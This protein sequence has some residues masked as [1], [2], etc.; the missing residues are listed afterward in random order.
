M[1]ITCRN[2]KRDN[3]VGGKA[4]VRILGFRLNFAFYLNS[5]KDDDKKKVELLDQL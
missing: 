5:A 2:S 4:F 3:R 1:Y